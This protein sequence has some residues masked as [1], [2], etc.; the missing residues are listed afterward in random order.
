MAIV[1]IAINKKS[2]EELQTKLKSLEHDLNKLNIDN[3]ENEILNKDKGTNPDDY[4]QLKLPRTIDIKT[5]IRRIDEMNSLIYENEGPNSKFE[6]EDGKIFKLKQI[7]ELLIS[8][9][10]NG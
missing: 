10:K 2:K 9:Y 4:D 8:F 5:I 1:K 7:K 6:T 3:G